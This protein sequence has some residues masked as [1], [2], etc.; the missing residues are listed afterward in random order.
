MVEIVILFFIAW[1]IIITK[2]PFEKNALSTHKHFIH[3]FNY[4]FFLFS[5]LLFNIWG[6]ITIRF[7]YEK[8][9]TIFVITAGGTPVNK[10]EKKF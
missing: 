5:N 8:K 4:V 1:N 2:E 9:N 7:F 6:S 10:H 3:D